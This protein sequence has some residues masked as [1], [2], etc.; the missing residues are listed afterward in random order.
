MFQ[1]FFTKD[2]L[3]FLIL[4]GQL[5]NSLRPN[6]VAK[7]VSTPVI[8]NVYRINATHPAQE[9]DMIE[10]SSN[11]TPEIQSEHPFTIGASKFNLSICFPKRFFTLNFLL[12]R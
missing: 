1:V 5:Q 12:T 8:C 10:I 6:C 9:R 4:T 11:F 3:R 7:H 2:T